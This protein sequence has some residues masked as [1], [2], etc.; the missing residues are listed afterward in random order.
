MSVL[1]F[2]VDDSWAGVDTGTVL[3]TIPEILS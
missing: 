2:R 1:K 3:I